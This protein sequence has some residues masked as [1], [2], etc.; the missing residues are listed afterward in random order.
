MAMTYSDLMSETN[1][2]IRAHYITGH[3]DLETAI[4]RI[5]HGGLVD[6]PR[7]RAVEILGT[8]MTVCRA[9]QFVSREITEELIAARMAEVTA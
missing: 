7:E 6:L 2:S 8:P 9:Q 3:F 5:Q 1:D 4:A